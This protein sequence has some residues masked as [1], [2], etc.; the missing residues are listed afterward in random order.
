MFLQSLAFSLQPVLFYKRLV[1]VFLILGQR[2]LLLRS[3]PR[4]V[5]VQLLQLLRHLPVE[6]IERDVHGA[7]ALALGA[8][9][10]ASRQVHGP[11][12]VPRHVPRRPRAC[13]DRLGA[14]LV[15]QAL[16]AVAERA[17]APARHAADAAGE[18]LLPEGPPLG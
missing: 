1:V 6:E 14:V 4:L 5:A 16:L 18:L 11:D 13:V 9:G 17:D 7:G 2:P 8:P 10:A 12:D 15:A 3:Q